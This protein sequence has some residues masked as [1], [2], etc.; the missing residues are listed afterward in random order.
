MAWAANPADRN[1]LDA[2]LDSALSEEQSVR[3]TY[4]K[5][6]IAKRYY[7]EQFKPSTEPEVIA[8][9]DR[10]FV[11]VGTDFE[12]ETKKVTANP[13]VKKV[14]PEDKDQVLERRADET[15]NH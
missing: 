2:L 14:I 8:I 15:T 10:E 7:Q 4:E 9:A 6:E 12:V 3:E 1:G 13:Q 5:T 11:T